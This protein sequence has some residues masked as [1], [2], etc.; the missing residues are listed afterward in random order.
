MDVSDLINVWSL[1]RAE[2]DKS[3]R[4][5]WTHLSTLPSNNISLRDKGGAHKGIRND[6]LDITDVESYFRR[7]RLSEYIM[8]DTCQLVAKRCTHSAAFLLNALR[9]PVYSLQASW[10]AIAHSSGSANKACMQSA[11]LKVGK[12]CD[13]SSSIRVVRT[14]PVSG[15][16]FGCQIFWTNLAVGG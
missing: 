15:W 16:T 2:P 14:T 4:T 12:A 3:A 11:T 1:A 8:V 5:N 10:F 9:S 7:N 13:Q 6:F